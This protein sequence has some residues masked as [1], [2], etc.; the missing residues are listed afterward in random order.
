MLFVKKVS[1]IATLLISVSLISINT[2]SAQC[3]DDE[4]FRALDYYY[5]DDYNSAFTTLQP[6]LDCFWTYKTSYWDRPGVVFRVY[7]LIT[8]SY[9][10]LGNDDK[11]DEWE[12]YLIQFFSGKFDGGYVLDRLDN[13]TI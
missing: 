11:V 4:F 7:K 2:A 8:E 6:L 1:I 3:N 13:T 5:N 10:E 12:G 9:Y